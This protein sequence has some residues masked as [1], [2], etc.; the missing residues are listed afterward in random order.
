MN[1]ADGKSEISSPS[2]CEL[3]VRWMDRARKGTIPPLAMSE[4]GAVRC[5]L[6]LY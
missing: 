5:A 6:N 1:K 3:D 4:A 2:E